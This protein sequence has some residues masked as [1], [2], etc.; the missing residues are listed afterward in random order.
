MIL[1]N[2]CAEILGRIFFPFNRR[3]RR[4]FREKF[5]RPLMRTTG[6]IS[7]IDTL[8]IPVYIISFNQLSYVRQMV[9]SLEARGY[10]NIHI[11]DNAS[12]YPPLIEYLEKSPHRVHFMEKNWG[13]NVFW[14]CGQFAE[15][16][17]AGYYVITD[18]DIELPAGLPPDF[19]STLLKILSEYPAT[20]KVGLALHIDDLP[21][22]PDCDGIQRWESAFWNHQLKNPYGLEMYDADIDTTFALYRPQKSLGGDPPGHR[23]IRLAGQFTARHLP[24]YRAL[25]QGGAEGT[26]EEKYYYSHANGSSNWAKL[27]TNEGGLY[28]KEKRRR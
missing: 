23:A 7:D 26:D 13:H 25:G 9:D 3:H 16:I 8:N 11:I 2:L 28:G 17:A 1:R 22:N 4:I 6:E 21:K 5:I 27:V 18:P 10:G 24:W 12:D 14:Q 20:H 19:M 15:T